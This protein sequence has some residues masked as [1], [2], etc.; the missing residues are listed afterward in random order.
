MET[1]V[2][3]VFL[4]PERDR[5]ED[6]IPCGKEAVFVSIHPVT[7]SRLH[8]CREHAGERPEAK[9]IEEKTVNEAGY[10]VENGKAIAVGV[11]C[12]CDEQGAFC[13]MHGTFANMPVAKDEIS[14]YYASKRK[15][16]ERA[17]EA[18]EDAIDR[19]APDETIRR[20][21][22]ARDSAAYVGD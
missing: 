19:D 2:H 3:R 5:W 17:Q 6:G 4:D 1:C 11:I 20:L 10:Q 15:E 22:R 7:G 13:P 8:W 9:P 12:R 14:E 16:L 18:L 21:Q